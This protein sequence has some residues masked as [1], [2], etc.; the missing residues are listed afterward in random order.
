M[1]E[2]PPLSEEYAAKSPSTCWEGWLSKQTLDCSIVLSHIQVKMPVQI[3]RQNC[4]VIISVFYWVSLKKKESFG[5]LIDPRPDTWTWISM[6]TSEEKKKTHYFKSRYHKMFQP[7][8]THWERCKEWW[9]VCNLTMLA[10]LVCQDSENSVARINAKTFAVLSSSN[11]Y[12]ETCSDG[13]QASYRGHYGIIQDPEHEN[14]FSVTNKMNQV[15]LWK[16]PTPSCFKSVR[17]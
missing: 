7:V 14:N 15:C 16:V 17:P 2:G 8:S 4:P 3:K 11:D 5:G 13:T 12:T 1:W 10:E 6:T 9:E